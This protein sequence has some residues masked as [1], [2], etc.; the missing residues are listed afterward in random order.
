MQDV[1][2][3]QGG[4]YL[5][6]YQGWVTVQMVVVTDIP[7]YLEIGEC[8]IIVKYQGKKLTCRQCLKTGHVARECPDNNDDVYEKEKNPAKEIEENEERKRKENEEKSNEGSGEINEEKGGEKGNET[9]SSQGTEANVGAGRAEEEEEEEGR[10]EIEDEEEEVRAIEE[11]GDAGEEDGVVDEPACTNDGGEENIA[12]PP[13]V[14]ERK[15]SY[16]D[17]ARSTTGSDNESTGEDL[18]AQAITRETS[19]QSSEH[20]SQVLSSAAK[21]SKIPVGKD[22]DLNLTGRKVKITKT[23]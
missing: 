3:T 6:A 23:K 19:D 21:P 9:E 16:S 10:T 18:F 11:T 17:V 15:R 8:K 4:D 22:S 2:D 12:D 7:S 13:G 14:K 20:I 5:A 1:T